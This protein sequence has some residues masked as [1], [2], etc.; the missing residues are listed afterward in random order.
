MLSKIT[1]QQREAKTSRR[2]K[3]HLTKERNFRAVIIVFIQY[4][5]FSLCSLRASRDHLKSF[6]QNVYLY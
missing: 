1:E 3:R 2:R 4:F 5:H 6:V